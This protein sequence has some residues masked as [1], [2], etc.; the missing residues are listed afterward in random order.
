MKR[1]IAT[2]LLLL[3]IGG[4]ILSIPAYADWT[5]GTA[6]FSGSTPSHCL[7][8]GGVL[9]YYN[10]EIKQ[11]GISGNVELWECTGDVCIIFPKNYSGKQIR[12]TKSAGVQVQYL[13]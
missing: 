9:I 3:G 1:F 8:H 10:G 2:L 12:F 4:T 5:Y 13:R 7:N 11:T 6:R